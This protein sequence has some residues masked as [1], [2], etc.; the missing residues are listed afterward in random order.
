[1]KNAIMKDAQNE[2]SSV[3]QDAQ[4]ALKDLLTPIMSE[5]EVRR[6]HSKKTV[7]QIQQEVRSDPNKVLS[8][9]VRHLPKEK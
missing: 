9:I 5:T 4:V 8:E 1:M 2:V 7:A 3:L 6:E